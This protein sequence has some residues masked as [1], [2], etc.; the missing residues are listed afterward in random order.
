MTAI[1]LTHDAP[2]FDLSESYF[3]DTAGALRRFWKDVP[4]SVI[5]RRATVEARPSAYTE[6]LERVD[7][8]RDLP[9]SWDSYGASRIENAAI[10][11]T[12][13]LLVA[14]EVE[15]EHEQE[16]G[17]PCFA[18]PVADGGVQLEWQS[19][20]RLLEVTVGPDGSLRYLLDYG[21]SALSPRFRSGPS[22]QSRRRSASPRR[23]ST[24][25]N[26]RRADPRQRRGRPEPALP[27]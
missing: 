1:S 26:D 6:L 14:L 5:A 19:A 10:A 3:R 22:P 9:E 4:R 2:G 8:F 25:G 24:P 23:P 16:G 15:L 13:K 12:K 11:T 17:A 18:G 20:D 7:A 27:S 21:R